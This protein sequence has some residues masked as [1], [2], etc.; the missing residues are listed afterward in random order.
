MIYLSHTLIFEL[1]DPRHINKSEEGLWWSI[2]I[3]LKWDDIKHNTWDWKS[4]RQTVYIYTAR[5]ETRKCI[6]SHQTLRLHTIKFLKLL[7]RLERMYVKDARTCLRHHKHSTYDVLVIPKP[8]VL[9]RSVVSDSLWPHGLQP[10][11][12]VCPWG[13]SRQ[14]YMPSSWGSSQPRDWTQVSRIAGRFFTIQP[15]REALPNLDLCI[16]PLLLQLELF[17][18]EVSHYFHS[19]VFFFFL[20]SCT[21][22]H[23]T[24]PML[25][26]PK[27]ESI[28]GNHSSTWTFT[29]TNA[30]AT[31]IQISQLQVIHQES[32]GTSCPRFKDAPEG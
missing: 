19:Y 2:F 18:L 32:S 6:A 14:Q 11:R 25:I 28:L 1:T 17:C 4:F 12:L 27:Q 24:S 22:W 10:S 9:T 31:I 7:S 3:I 16:F 21:L 13:F 29:I 15:N 8:A 20:F 30:L 5:K 26:M 23:L